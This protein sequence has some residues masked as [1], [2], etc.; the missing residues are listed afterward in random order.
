[1]FL[2]LNN[3]FGWNRLPKSFMAQNTVFLLMTALIRNFYK[4]IMQRLK[5]R[6]FGL[7]ATSRIKTFVFKFISVPAK[8][9]KT[10]RRHVLK[11][12][13]G[14]MLRVLSMRDMAP[15]L[16]PEAL[17]AAAASS[18]ESVMAVLWR[19]PWLLWPRLWYVV[20]VHDVV[21]RPVDGL[22]C[23]GDGGGAARCA[24]HYWPWCFWARAMRSLP[25]RVIFSFSI[26]VTLSQ[27]GFVS[28]QLLPT[29]YKQ[30]LES[31]WLFLF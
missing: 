12:S 7:R 16:S 31:H 13:A 30:G 15:C 4:A 11:V 24:W 22:A 8:W 3:G 19:P 28:T 27:L 1:M 17:R 14:R 5:T 20:W 9:I 21:R 23:G 2:W 6:E 29:T 26:H 25:S 18:R 10:S